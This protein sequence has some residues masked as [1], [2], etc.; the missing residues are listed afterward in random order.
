[1]RIWKHKQLRPRL[2]RKK[3]KKKQ[4]R[5]RAEIISNYII[6]TSSLIIILQV[7]ARITHNLNL[8][9]YD[10]HVRSYVFLTR[11]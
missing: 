7:L 11:A 8:Y 10:F 5:P 1:M 9:R 2:S 3:E 4:L 6:T